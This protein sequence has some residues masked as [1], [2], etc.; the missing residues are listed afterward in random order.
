MPRKKAEVIAS[1]DIAV[2]INA[3]LQAQ[4]EAALHGGERTPAVNDMTR[5]ALTLRAKGVNDAD[6]ATAE[7]VEVSTLALW[8]VSS[9]RMPTAAEAQRMITE[10]IFPLAIENQKHLLLAGDKRATMET[11][12]QSGAMKPKKKETASLSILVGVGTSPVGNDP[13]ESQTRVAVA[14]S[15]K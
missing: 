11:M 1:T 6:I 9:N 13:L 14:V 7:Q 10:E 2:V 3:P 8:M 15:L 4:L 5:R 12:K